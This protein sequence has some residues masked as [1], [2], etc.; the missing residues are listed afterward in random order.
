MKQT[1]M[2]VPFCFASCRVVSEFPLRT[3]CLGRSPPFP[4]RLEKPAL[5]QASLGVTPFTCREAIVRNRAATEADEGGGYTDLE[6]LEVINPGKAARIRLRQTRYFSQHHVVVW[7]LLSRR[8]FDVGI[9][10]V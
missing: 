8:I 6:V 2:V 7:R 5:H 9:Y 3:S 10:S 4:S 1:K